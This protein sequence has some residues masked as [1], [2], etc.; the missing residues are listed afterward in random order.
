MPQQLIYTSAPHGLAAGRSGH[1]TVA[2]SASMREPLVLRLEQL[3]YYQHLSLTGGKE[4]P[5]LAYRIIDIRGSRFHVLSRIQD[6]GLDFTGR[7]NFIAHHLVLAPEDFRQFPTPPIILG[8]WPGWVKSW[9]REPTLFESE[10]WSD[11]ASLAG[12]SSVPAQTWQHVTGDSVNGYGLLEARTGATFR[13]DDQTNDTVLGLFAESIELLEVRDPRRDFRAAGLQYTFTTSLQEQDNPSDFRWRCI[14][15]DNPAANRLATPDCRALSAVRATKWT[16]EETAF[17]REGRTA[18]KFVVEP[19]DVQIIEGQEA[20]FQAKAEGIPNPTYQWYSV[21]RADNGQPLTG[22]TNQEL[23]LS[24]STLGK[25]R[26]VVRVSNSAGDAISRTATLSV[27]QKPRLAQANLASQ[28]RPFAFGHQKTE[29]DIERQ[30]KQLQSE[31]AENRFR[32]KQRLKRSI[33]I[34]ALIVTTFIVAIACFIFMNPKYH[35]TLEKFAERLPFL[36]V[37]T[38]PNQ[39]NQSPSTNQSRTIAQVDISPVHVMGTNKDD[40]S[41]NVQRELAATNLNE[42]RG[43]EWGL[44]L[45]W[46][47]ATIGNVQNKRAE[48][49][50][51][52]NRFDVEAVASGFASNSDNVFFTYSTNDEGEFRV[53]LKKWPPADST[54]GIMVRQSLDSNSPFLFIGTSS[55]RIVSYSRDTES[56]YRDRTTNSCAEKLPLSLWFN[57]G[58]NGYV[59]ARWESGVANSTGWNLRFSQNKLLVGFAVLSAGTNCGT[60]QFFYEPNRTIATKIK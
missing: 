56:K 5:I 13:V 12:K 38:F 30:R 15:S 17:A 48:Y 42:G 59:A 44:P 28:A 40:S 9:T 1:C 19:Q 11:L 22:A 33:S 34:V 58:A 16:T 35:S 52:V 31:E 55:N 57:V 24:N 47:I 29:S 50:P 39:T 14:H 2:R 21:D 46:A 37:F 10:D 53:Q 51:T 54:V 18:P 41:T 7:T 27:E 49:I 36:R 32:R 26:Y 20:R 60:A 3:S 25:S 6:A 8:D 23:T 45:G 4:R 43:M